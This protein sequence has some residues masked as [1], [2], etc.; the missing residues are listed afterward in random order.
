VTRDDVAAVFAA[1][2]PIGSS[3]LG[4]ELTLVDADGA[5]S[6]MAD[7]NG[8]YRTTLR[9]F[10]WEV[11]EDGSRSI[12]D[13]KEQEIWSGRLGEQTPERLAAFIQGWDAAFRKLLDTGVQMDTY[14]P[15]DLCGFDALGLK[16]MNTAEEFA[17]AMLA[18][19]RLGRCLPRGVDAN[20]LDAG[21][22]GVA[23]PRRDDD[24]L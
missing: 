7:E 12:R 9:L 11:A 3:E 17:Q 24:A 22:P 5:T 4:V 2:F 18:R 20:A 16:T 10:V 15:H 19:K 6:I 14:M 1:N 21:A 8:N 13:I 23:A